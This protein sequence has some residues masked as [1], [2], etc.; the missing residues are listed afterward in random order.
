MTAAVM[1]SGKNNTCQQR[2]KYGTRMGS[3]PVLL[4]LKLAA[5][6]EMPGN[7][8]ALTNPLYIVYPNPEFQPLI[9]RFYYITG[10]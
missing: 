1:I 5:L 6:Q 8:M 2:R 9:F 3:R 4:V 10:S 7:R